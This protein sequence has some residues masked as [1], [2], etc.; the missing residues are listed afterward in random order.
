ML[1][2]S[3]C[4]GDQN[5]E[6]G[7]QSAPQQSGRS[8][9]THLKLVAKTHVRKSGWLCLFG[10]DK[11]ADHASWL[12]RTR[13]GICTSRTSFPRL[14]QSS[15]CRGLIK[16]LALR[17]LHSPRRPDAFA[18]IGA[19]PPPHDCM[20][21]FHPSPHWRPHVADSQWPG[22]YSPSTTVSASIRPRQ[23]CWRRSTISCSMDVVRLTRFC[24][25][26]S[27]MA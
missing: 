24:Q 3:N 6:S 19:S 9:V 20:T 12:T 11:E 15:S 4:R 23:T 14:G 1:G 5:V 16:E 8:L 7:D 10:L 22:P 17:F 26:P 2:C 13:R 21:W 25:P 18:C 27:F